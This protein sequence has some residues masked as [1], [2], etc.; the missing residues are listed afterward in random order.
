MKKFLNKMRG[1]WLLLKSPHYMVYGSKGNEELSR[2]AY[3]G[4]VGWEAAF[5]WNERVCAK[6]MDDETE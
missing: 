1:V 3:A 6:L 5:E 2:I 4:N